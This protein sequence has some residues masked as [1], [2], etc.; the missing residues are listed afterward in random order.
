VVDSQ[1]QKIG[2]DEVEGLW[3]QVELGLLTPKTEAGEGLGQRDDGQH[4]RQ[5]LDLG[6]WLNADETRERL[7]GRTWKQ[8]LRPR[9]GQKSAE[10]GE[11]LTGVEL[12]AMSG[13]EASANQSCEFEPDLCQVTI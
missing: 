3:R 11:A 5:Q 2:L 4:R 6:R 8:I 9:G 1:E 12:R 7:V 13:L 10:P